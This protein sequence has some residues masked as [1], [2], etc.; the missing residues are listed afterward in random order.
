MKDIEET[1]VNVNKTLNEINQG[2]KDAQISK[3]SDSM[4]GFLNTSEATMDELLELRKTID[5]S[6]QNANDTMEAAKAL[7]Q[8][9][10][11]HPASLING[12]NDK[13]VVKP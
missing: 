4:N 10:N 5:I 3:L 7:M 12:R 2:I 6:L 9:I 8:Y 11:E 13:P 1:M